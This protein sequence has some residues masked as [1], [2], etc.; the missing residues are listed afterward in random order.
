VRHETAHNFYEHEGEN[1][2]ECPANA[3]LIPNCGAVAMVTPMVPL[4]MAGTILVSLVR[5]VQL[6][7]IALGHI[8]IPV[9]E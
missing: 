5:A 7:V 8:R 4:R 1:D 9:S 3:P 6:S 2:N